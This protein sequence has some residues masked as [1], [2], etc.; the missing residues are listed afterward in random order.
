MVGLPV[1]HIRTATQLNNFVTPTVAGST[2]GS[3]FGSK[4]NAEGLLGF[5]PTSGTYTTDAW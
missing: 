2:F 3:E 5:D 4:P 1:S